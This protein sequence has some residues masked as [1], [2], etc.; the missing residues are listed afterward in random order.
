[1]KPITLGSDPELFL[2]NKKGNPVSAIG[3]F[4][5]TKKKPKRLSI[6]YIQEDNVTLEFNVPPASTVEEWVKYHTSMLRSINKL[7]AAKGLEIN[8]VPAMEF[9]QKYLMDT[10]QAMEFGCSPAFDATRNGI[11]IEPPS[12]YTTW[13]SAGGHIHIGS[14]AIVK[15]RKAM[16]HTVTALASLVIKMEDVNEAFMKRLG[17]YGSPGAMRPTPYGVEWRAPTNRWLHSEESM[18]WIW[19][20]VTSVVSAAGDFNK[21]QSIAENMSIMP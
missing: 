12:P 18:R 6:G 1:M 9:P 15:D 13:R 4:G 7:A 16:F 20:A 3:L 14:E 5:G 10:P 2:V 8:L 17:M 21:Q 19:N 11:V